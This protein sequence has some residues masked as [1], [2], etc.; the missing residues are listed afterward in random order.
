MWSVNIYVKDFGQIRKPKSAKL[1]PLCTLNFHFQISESNQRSVYPYPSDSF[2][3]F[4]A[5]KGVNK[6]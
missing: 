5:H 3:Y 1:A 4:E 6:N 2:N